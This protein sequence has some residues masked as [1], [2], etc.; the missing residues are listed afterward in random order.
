LTI[1][2]RE[3]IIK[4]M[5]DPSVLSNYSLFDGLEKE[6]IE[7][8]LPLMEHEVYEAGTDIIVEGTH[9]GKIRFILEGKVAVVKNGF[10]LMELDEGAVFGEME[11]VDIQ[12]AEA[13]VKAL[14]STSVM[15]LSIDALG[16]IYETDLKTYSFILMNLA[17]DISRRLRRMDLLAAKE[18]PHMEW[19]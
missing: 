5:I 8:I 7:S 16:E 19:N 13:S 6:E 4:T 15:T 12:P 9:V 14:V 11:V 18:S 1:T 2:K 17:R 3:V 10:I